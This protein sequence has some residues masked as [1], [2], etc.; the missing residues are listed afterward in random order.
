MTHSKFKMKILY[1]ISTHTLTWSVTTGHK[2][3]KY[4]IFDFNS[5]A[6]VERD[7]LSPRFKPVVSNFNS[8]AHVERDRS[9]HFQFLQIFHFN[10]HAHVERDILKMSFFV[11]VKYFNSHAHVERDGMRAWYVMPIRISTH[12]LTWSV[13]W[14]WFM[15]TDQRSISTHTLTWSVT[16]PKLKILT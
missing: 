12:T 5:H 11:P 16:K 8:H 14:E 7:L 4:Y 6:H 13:T 9:C 15:E 10:S 2:F 3:V 1:I